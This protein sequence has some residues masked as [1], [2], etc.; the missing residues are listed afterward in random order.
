M[1]A[2]SR[3]RL[4]VDERKQQL[5][6]LA[7]ELFGGKSYEEISIDEFA[8]RGGISKGLLYHYF[9]SKRALYVA[10]V[11][12]AAEQLL[13]KTHVD[14]GAP[15][16]SLETVKRGLDAYLAYV[17]EHAAAYAFLL[18][19]GVGSDGDVARLVEATR[20]EFAAR[21][22]AGLGLGEGDAEGRVLVRG[23]V[24]FVEATSLA[25]VEEPSIPR[26][27]LLDLILGAFAAGVQLVK[28]Q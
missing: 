9:P 3:Q 13:E 23:W 14:G 24:G 8:K 26:G 18:R 7:I 5:L 1:I 22:S 28:A 25:W 27:R 16:H 6:D 21:I 19:S 10:A 15:P 20:S 4:Q 11:G 17:E 2:P 12:R